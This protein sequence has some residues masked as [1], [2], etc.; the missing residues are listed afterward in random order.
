MTEGCLD[1]ARHER[2]LEGAPELEI[3]STS[4]LSVRVEHRRDTRKASAE[5]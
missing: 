5:H 3:A 2:I 4:P 1:W